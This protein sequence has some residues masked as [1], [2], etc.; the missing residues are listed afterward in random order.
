MGAAHDA[1]YPEAF[2]E[3]RSAAQVEV[4][5]LEQLDQARVDWE[6]L[7]AYADRNVFQTR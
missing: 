5:E 4:M 3:G 7:D 6:E 1:A 2:E